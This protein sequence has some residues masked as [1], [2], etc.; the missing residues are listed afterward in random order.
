MPCG[1][2]CITLKGETALFN[3]TEVESACHTAE[4]ALERESSGALIDALLTLKDWLGRV[5][6]A[7]AGCGAMP[8]P[9]GADLCAG[10]VK[11]AGKSEC[12]CRR[13]G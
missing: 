9:A 11:P 6:A 3:M 4:D 13:S 7:C 12:Q 8:P 1:G 10:G 2:F 5:F